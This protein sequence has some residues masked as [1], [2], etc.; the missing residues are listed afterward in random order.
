MRSL[1]FWS[2]E[3]YHPVVASSDGGLPLLYCTVMTTCTP[4]LALGLVGRGMDNCATS[5]VK[6]GLG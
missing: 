3:V 4:T 1:H 2:P 6:L 5:F